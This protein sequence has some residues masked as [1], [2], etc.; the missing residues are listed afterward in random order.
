MKIRSPKKSVQ[1]KTQLNKN[2][3]VVI[4]LDP[5][6]LA[7][8]ERLKAEKTK[9]LE[10][11]AE[12]EDKPTLK[13][14][15]RFVEDRALSASNETDYN[16]SHENFIRDEEDKELFDSLMIGKRV[17]VKITDSELQSKHG[18]IGG[19]KEKICQPILKALQQFNEEEPD[20]IQLSDNAITEKF[21]E[22]LLS[23]DRYVTHDGRDW[24]IYVQDGDVIF[25]EPD[26]TTK[27]IKIR[28]RKLGTIRREY[29][30]KLRQV[31][32]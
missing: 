27:K 4:Y 29:I 7:Y 8:P 18:K 22:W 10:V 3:K 2:E 21:K 12:T 31:G 1:Q 26:K 23:D 14:L 11:V 30:P 16:I 5:E 9:I 28:S 20:V 17:G 19:D 24:K 6:K 25:A 32:T 15:R 13:E